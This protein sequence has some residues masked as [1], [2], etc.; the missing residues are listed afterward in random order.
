MVV[1]KEEELIRVGV[2]IQKEYGVV[3]PVQ[4]KRLPGLFPVET[5]E[6]IAREGLIFSKECGIQIGAVK[7][8]WINVV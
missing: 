6:T 8:D 7:T 5:T 4:C 1:R 2:V 3:I